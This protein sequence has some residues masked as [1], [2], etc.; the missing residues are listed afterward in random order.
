MRYQKDTLSAVFA[1]PLMLMGS[2]TGQ[3]VFHGYPLW[4]AESLLVLSVLAGAGMIVGVLLAI[5]GPTNLRALLLAFLLLFFIDL[6][7]GLIATIH[8]TFSV[9]AGYPP[10]LVLV[11]R[12]IIAFGVLIII[13]PMREHIATICV[14]GSGAFILSTL[15]VPIQSIEFGAENL[16]GPTPSPSDDSVSI[17]LILDGLIGVE[18]VPLDIE[19]GP[20]MKAA[21]MQFYERWGFRLFGRAYSP[22]LMTVNSIGNSLN[23]AAS[24]Q[25]V[26]SVINEEGVG[27]R[28]RLSRNQSFQTPSSRDRNIRIY[29]SDY[30]NYCR[31]PA[32]R[33]SFCFTYPASSFVSLADAELAPVM[34][35]RLIMDAFVSQ[36]GV[37][38]EL[39]L[40]FATRSYFSGIAV[41]DVIRAIRDDVLANPTGT[42]FF[43]HLLLPHGPYIWDSQCRLRP[44]ARQWRSRRLYHDDLAAVGTT[45]FR[46]LA[47]KDY[48][49]QVHCVVLLLDNLFESMAEAGI[50]QDAT[51]VVHGDHGSRITIRDPIVYHLDELTQRDYVDSFSTFFAIRS[52]DVSPSYDPEMRPLPNLV[53][54]YVLQ[55]QA[56]MEQSNLYLR[57]V[58]PLNSEELMIAP[59]PSF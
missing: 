9:A 42:L 31:D 59:M 6:Q 50:M 7:F 10:W 17:H 40:A 18:G 28:F 16:D 29:Q 58:S 19:G 55:Q 39:Y 21:L 48:F 45:A 4:S 1:P 36:S 30:I 13:L 57:G 3:L 37:L 47:Y 23:G 24:D 38:R 5:S 54:E 2:M 43:A 26:T 35:A 15:I 49:E 52:P 25:D 44:D 27:R 8:D 33:F 56:P 22:Y 11:G 20:E 41:P 32:V 46:E 12:F 53:A 34:K 51:I 14:A